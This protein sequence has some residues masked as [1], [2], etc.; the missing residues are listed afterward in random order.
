LRKKTIKKFLLIFV[1]GLTISNIAFNNSTSPNVGKN[2][3]LILKNSANEDHPQ[4]WTGIW[5]NNGTVV[6]QESSSQITPVVCSDGLGGVIV[7]W[8]DY[9]DDIFGDIHAQRISSSGE[10]LWEENGIA[11]CTSINNQENPELCSDGNGGAIIAWWDY[12]SGSHWDVFA[13]RVNFTGDTQW[14]DNGTAICN[15]GGWQQVPQIC[16]DGM[17]G[18]IITWYDYRGADYDIYAQRLDSNGIAQWTPNGTAICTEIFNQFDPKLI[19]DGQGGAIITWE[20]SRTLEEDIYA[21]HINSAGDV[22]WTPNGTV[23]CNMSGGQRF[24]QLC[25]D[26]N[27]GA[28][29]TWD[30][31]R[32]W[33]VSLIDIYTQRVNSSGEIVWNSQ[34]IPICT[35]SGWTITPVLCSDEAGGAIIT[36]EDDRNGG[37]SGRDIYAQL[38][39][40]NGSILWQVNGTPVC[41]EFGDQR[42]PQICINGEGG[43]FIAWSDKRSGSHYDVYAQVINSTADLLLEING[44]ALCTEVEDQLYLR[45]CN[46]GSNGAFLT[47]NDERNEVIYTDIYAQYLR[48]NLPPTSS[49]PGSIITTVGGSETIEIT[50]YDDLGEGKYRVW[51]NDTNNN[52]YIWVNWTLWNNNTPFYI[53]IN[54]SAPGIYNYV[55]EYYDAYNLYGVP[56]LV[57]VEIIDGLP[58]SNHP[59]DIIASINSVSLICWKLYD[60]YGGGQYRVM[61]NSN[62]WVDWTS[63]VNNTFIYIP[64]NST[65]V[66]V[67]YYTIEFTSNTNQIATDTVIVT[68]VGPEQPPPPSD[69][70]F[71][72][73]I[74]FGIIGALTVGN[75]VLTYIIYRKFKRRLNSE[76]TS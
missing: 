70:S 73:W 49:H 46:D 4:L 52:Y 6:C 57:I 11:I 76:R 15:L 63:W 2:S 43:A 1:I 31:Y 14:E 35:E 23:I 32:N 51:I 47:W 45:I 75:L 48:K 74:G 29:I 62:T 8:V 72:I 28:I 20:D 10:M 7:A 34:G 12:R 60:D 17:G 59:N 67:F 58:S 26:G 68:I 33:S 3:S 61:I 65:I 56:E 55:I 66:G 9:R 36:W 54:R 18:A 13:Q 21:Q 37:I 39:N 40:S 19:S 71:L 27:G 16:S 38:I 25:S 69:Q 41:T 44:T 24:P 50:L 53:P 5:G 30:D 42:T 22:Q 64:I